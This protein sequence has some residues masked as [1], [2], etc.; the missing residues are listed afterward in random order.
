[1]KA[2]V[3]AALFVAAACGETHPATAQHAADTVPLAKDSVVAFTG[4]AP[5][6]QCA[7][8]PARPVRAVNDTAAAGDSA[9][10]KEAVITPPPKSR[11]RAAANKKGRAYAD[12]VRAPPE[13]PESLPGSLFPG[14][15]VLAYY[16][17]PLSKRMG[18]LGALP[19]DS[20][21]AKLARHAKEYQKLDSAMPVIVALQL[22]T[23]VAQAAP[24]SGG[25]Y[26]LRMKDSTIEHFAAL[27]EKA[28][29][30]LVLDMQVGKSTVG[31]ELVPLMQFLQRPN[32][33]LALD[34]EFSVKRKDKRP[35]QVIGTLD[36]EDVNLAIDTLAAL[37][38]RYHL[39]PKMLVVH[40]FTIPMLTHAPKI[41]LDPRVQVVLDMDGF[42]PP[43][44]KYG[45]YG[46]YAHDRPVEFPG[47]KLFFKQDVPM[48]T[49]RQVLGLD[50]QPVYVQ[51]Q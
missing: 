27:A 42:G 51:Y 28:H 30:L 40:R 10:K 43:E 8:L 38:T 14:C 29:G 5:P 3:C 6:A 1:M 2:A 34:A 21:L 24:G 23:P 26:R 7:Q 12:T 17:N 41:K 39:P 11:S 15:R 50:P 48:L 25:K 35:G 49:P 32:V 45:S 31:A 47:V 9:K 33:H 44:D 20:M 19:G 13:I 36:A 18:I 4:Y 37:V 22:V 46:A 16:G